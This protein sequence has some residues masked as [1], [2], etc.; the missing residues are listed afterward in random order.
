MKG[1]ARG[2]VVPAGYELPGNRIII[3]DSHGREAG[4]N[5]AGDIVVESDY[6]FAG[7]WAIRR[8]LRIIKTPS[9]KDSI[10]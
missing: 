10:P 2:P 4:E 6:L 9:T 5:V 3:L 8:S 1:G 7:Y